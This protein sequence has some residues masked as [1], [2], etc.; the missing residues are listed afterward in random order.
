MC[1]AA[2]LRWAI[3]LW[4]A[5]LPCV[6]GGQ[7]TWQYT[8]E[9]G[10]TL[11][12]IARQHLLAESY[13][14]QVQR[15]NHVIDPYRLQPG[16]TLT[17][18]LRIT[19][20]APATAHLQ[21]VSGA[22]ELIRNGAKSV[23]VSGLALQP[24][25]ELVCGAE[26]N[27]SVEFAD[28]SRARV[29]AGSHV[30]LSQMQRLGQSK[31]FTTEI[32]LKQGRIESS[33]VQKP[34]GRQNYL[35]RTPTVDLGVRGT[36]FR[37]AAESA[38]AARTEVLQGL[39]AAA[40]PAG[41]V[42]VGAGFGTVTKL[43]QAPQKPRRL[44]PPADL[45]RL[46]QYVAQR[47]PI[48][49]S[50]PPVAGAQ[51]Y[52][53]QV[54]RDANFAEIVA[55]Q[56]SSKAEAKLARDIGD[57]RYAVR[58]RAIDAIQLE[59]QD[60]VG[61]LQVKTHPL[62]PLTESPSNKSTV[63]GDQA[64]FRWTRSDE[65]S[66]YR[67]QVSSAADF[68][69]IALDAPSLEATGLSATLA[70][71]E[72][73]WRVASVREPSDQGPFGQINKFT[74]KAMPAFGEQLPLDSRSFTLEWG[75]AEPGQRFR[76]QLARNREFAP[77]ALERMLSEAKIQLPRPVGGQFFVRMSVIEADGSESGFGPV[78][79]I[80]LP[81][82]ELPITYSLSPHLLHLRWPAVLQP[83]WKYQWQLAQDTNFARVVRDE[84]GES[85]IPSIAR[86]PEGGT[87]YA[88]VR[89]IDAHGEA[90][91]FGAVARIDMPSLRPW[92]CSP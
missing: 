65:A 61:A 22:V 49:F 46:S 11:I 13:W 58:V 12:S 64:E 72:Y 19:R 68:S 44:L 7:Q 37:A 23:A 63:R 74:L 52:R 41:S 14:R 70:P 91:E 54:A 31:V 2:C 17:L 16:S 67:L 21:A 51:A 30:K 53:V 87:Y 5:L 39:V 9:R 10:D 92:C 59:G 77:L 43:N 42:G 28:G 81:P 20:V 85:S 89:V 8:I 66:R 75:E 15:L 3:G 80:R 36:E 4:A 55:D 47:L 60:A 82:H 45:S 40:N 69:T 33:V 27:A 86:L 34:R 38:D 90:G 84:T 83:G 50:W 88:R 48:A 32:E 26:G 35:I 57:G 29:L 78:Q 71:G 25:D 24:G 1:R 18:P 76:F 56:L 79:S 6:S 73:Y 62:P